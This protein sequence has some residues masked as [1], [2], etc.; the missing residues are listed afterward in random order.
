M[1]EDD[2]SKRL[3]TQSQSFNLQGQY[4]AQN[5]LTKKE[6]KKTIQELLNDPQ[7]KVNLVCSCFIWLLSSFNFYLITFYLKYF[8]GNVF[9][10]SLCFAGADMIAFISSGVILNKISVSRGL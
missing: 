1:I 8:P 6:E 9:V 10:N 3:R 4:I 7:L 5:E 2:G